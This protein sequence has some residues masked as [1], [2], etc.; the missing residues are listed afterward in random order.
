METG[1][2]SAMSPDIQGPGAGGAHHLHRE[3][4]AGQLAVERELLTQPGDDVCGNAGA[5]PTRDHDADLEHTGEAPVVAAQVATGTASGQREA[6]Q[7]DGTRRRFERHIRVRDRDS[8]GLR[9]DVQ[10]SLEQLLND[11]VTHT[12]F[13]LTAASTICWNSAMVTRT[14]PAGAW[15]ECPYSS[16]TAYGRLFTR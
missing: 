12:W 2:V 7:I 13:A 10:A 5:L 15:L 1:L 9:P 11:L 8:L 14:M 4:G 6:A 16:G 3:T